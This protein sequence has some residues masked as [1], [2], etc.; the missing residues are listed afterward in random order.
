[1]QRKQN[2]LPPVPMNIGPG[3]PVFTNP[4]CNLVNDRLPIRRSNFSCSSIA[5]EPCHPPA[6]HDYDGVPNAPCFQRLA[7][8]AKPSGR[9]EQD[10]ATIGEA[11]G[12]VPPARRVSAGNNESPRHSQR[13]PCRAPTRPL[14][15]RYPHCYIPIHS[16]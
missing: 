10:R 11:Q 1:M 14:K 16:P 9:L 8:K 7:M 15:R 4:C 12:Q 5:V 3:S 2:G 13:R 6:W